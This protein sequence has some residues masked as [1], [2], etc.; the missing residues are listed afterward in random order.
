MVLLG[1]LAFSCCSDPYA[2][3]KASELL[4]TALIP[5]VPP[6]PGS[7][8]GFLSYISEPAQGD[9]NERPQA[10][11]DTTG[12]S[13]KHILTEKQL[14]RST[15]LWDIVDIG[16]QTVAPLVSANSPAPL[17]Q[18]NAYSH[19]R[20]I[21]HLVFFGWNLLLFS[22]VITFLCFPRA[23]NWRSRVG[24]CY[25]VKVNV[26]VHFTLAE[27]VIKASLNVN[28]PGTLFLSNGLFE[29]ALF[30][31]WSIFSLQ[32]SPM[33]PFI[34]QNKAGMAQLE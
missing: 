29:A 13:I 30:F 23:D 22:I 10:V 27:T 18:R 6:L 14:K 25:G 34:P 21:P 19:L 5:R 8:L 28:L 16:L 32:P 24:L 20:W 2:L 7:A 15:S 4:G 11:S 31:K 33:S 9:V 3:P 12:G 26:K 17:R 1:C